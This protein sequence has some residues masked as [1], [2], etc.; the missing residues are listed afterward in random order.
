M[1]KV[2]PIPDGFRSVTPHLVTRSAAQAIDFYKQAFGAVERYRM[3]G[4]GGTIMHAEITIGD[5]IVMLGEES[6][7]CPE[8]KCPAS[9]GGS[10]TTISLYVP[11]ADK[12]FDRAVKAGANVVM[13]VMDMFW[14]DRY[15]MVTDPSGHRWAIMT[16]VKDMT[17]D[18]IMKAGA[19]FMSSMGKDGAS[20]GSSKGSSKGAGNGASKSNGAKNRLTPAAASSS[21]APAAK[22]GTASPAP[23]KTVSAKPAVAKKK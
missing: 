9:L 7:M 23:S 5:S 8:N 16:H 22:P 10:A 20:Q 14:G 2:K 13:P 19:A 21:K 11:D 6:P 1:A 4:P 18:E 17:P 15:G 3:P 12:A